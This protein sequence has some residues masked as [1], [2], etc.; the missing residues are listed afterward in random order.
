ME[1]KAV[2][3]EDSGQ[4]G[5]QWPGKKHGTRRRTQTRRRVNVKE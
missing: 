3:E 5:G 4:E 2:Y 1:E